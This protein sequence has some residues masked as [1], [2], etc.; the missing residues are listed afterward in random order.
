MP[1]DISIDATIFEA[2]E[3]SSS[4]IQDFFGLSLIAMLNK[5][6]MDLK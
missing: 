2:F 3:S 4:V 1:D 5:D 6:T